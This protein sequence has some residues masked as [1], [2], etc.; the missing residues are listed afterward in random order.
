MIMLTLAFNYGVVINPALI[1]SMKRMV[2]GLD[3]DDAQVVG[4]EIAMSVGEGLVVVE[5]VEYIMAAIRL[6][7][8]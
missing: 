7:R 1:L 8:G 3:E 6:G 2:I 5:T 4:T